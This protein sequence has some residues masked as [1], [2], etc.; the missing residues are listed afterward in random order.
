MSLSGSVFADEPIMDNM[1][2]KGDKTINVDTDS[3]RGI[4]LSGNKVVSLDKETPDASLVIKI[5]GQNAVG[6]VRYGAHISGNS[7]VNLSDVSIISEDRT[8]DVNGVYITGMKSEF[9]TNNLTIAVS[10]NKNY[11]VSLNGGAQ[12]NVAGNIMVSVLGDTVPSTGIRAISV[13]S[14]SSALKVQGNLVL[15][16]EGDQRAYGIYNTGGGKLSV[17]KDTYIK[18][19]GN[20]GHGIFS[21]STNGNGRIELHGNLNIDGHGD[22]SYAI[23]MIGGLLDVGQDTFIRM[24]GN[25]SSGIH[26]SKDGNGLVEADIEL[27]GD[28]VV[29][30]DGERSKGIHASTGRIM[31]DGRSY[32]TMNSERSNGI[33]GEHSSQVILKGGVSI[34]AQKA[35]SQA[36]YASSGSSVELHD[37]VE[38][39]TGSDAASNA[40]KVSG[41]GTTGKKSIVSGSALF[42][43]RGNIQSLNGGVINLKMAEGSVWRGLSVMDDGKGSS[44]SID[45]GQGALWQ[46]TGNSKLT[47]LEINGATVDMTSD[48]VGYSTLTLENLAGNNGVVVMDID[49]AAVDQSDKLY[50]TGSFSGSQALKLHEINGRDNDPTLGLDALGT[51]LASVNISDGTFTAVDNEGSLFWQRY[52]LGQ[53]IS[54]ANGFSTDWYLKEIENIM[55]DER[56][57]TGVST[58]LSVNALNYYTW[59]TENDKMLQRLGELR[60]NGDADAGAW[61]RVDGSKIGYDGRFGFANKYTAYELGYD[62]VIKRSKKFLRYSGVALSYTDGSS[63]FNNGGGENKSGAI[64]FYSSQIGSN[65]HYLDVVLKMSR[66]KNDFAVYDSN[67]SRITGEFDNVGVSLSAEYGRK[68]LLSH[69]W[70]AEPQAQMTLGY[71]GGDNY[72][73]SNVLTVYQSGIKSAVGRI[74][75]NIGRDIDSKTNI[76][77]KINLLHEFGGGYDVKLADSR[78]N[79]FR[80]DGA[81]DNTWFEYGIG[82]AMQTGANSQIYVDIERSTGGNFTKEWHW[83][84]GARWN[85]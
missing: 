64:N 24:Y 52:E 40:I 19:T 45:L 22:N 20:I 81:F 53:K 80:T 44:S 38:I 10:G 55:P 23:R 76:Y 11:G 67:F 31:I 82:A 30:I 2:I 72:R 32:I 42:N 75:F 70:Y 69:G 59:R 77:A 62:K 54:D 57:T 46:M 27:H 16:A 1:V 9:N 73:T 29:I 7:K 79:S 6:D 83:N 47:D 8:G 12:M 49:G 28:A 41:E 51:V 66:S 85:F 37:I 18:T 61:F 65:G 17:E 48:N 26:T 68:K 5:T 50:V 21:A 35:G 25:N 14:V 74:G 33:L 78:G 84:V 39:K 71:L 4:S 13:N 58:V 56:P 60:H 43:M 3:N 36:I 34:D 63:S 15:K